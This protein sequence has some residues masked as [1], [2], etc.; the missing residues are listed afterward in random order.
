MNKSWWLSPLNIEKYNGIKVHNEHTHDNHNS[1]DMLLSQLKWYQVRNSKSIWRL[2]TITAVS[3]MS[4]IIILQSLVN[5]IGRRKAIWY[6][7]LSR[8]HQ[9]S[10]VQMVQWILI[11]LHLS[12][13]H[14]HSSSPPPAP[15]PLHTITQSDNQTAIRYRTLLSRVCDSYMLACKPRLWSWWSNIWIIQV[16]L[17]LVE[18]QLCLQYV[19]W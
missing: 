9:A 11:S 12:P 7:P 5:T 14:I 1:S 6:I 16:C 13:F 19:C 15:F 2:F 8:Q 17:T 10:L 3:I 18:A 4:E